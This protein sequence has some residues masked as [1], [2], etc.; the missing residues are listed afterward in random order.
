[1]KGTE[2]II[3][4]IL[5]DARAQAKKTVESAEYERAMSEK[6]TSDWTDGY[7]LKERKILRREC[8]EVVERKLTL[9]NCLSLKISNIFRSRSFVFIFPPKLLIIMQKCDK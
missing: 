8:D 5:S 4:K 1:M 7:L 6:A 3:D 9:A 2:G